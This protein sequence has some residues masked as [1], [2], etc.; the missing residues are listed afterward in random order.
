MKRL[1]ANIL[2]LIIFCT[3]GLWALDDKKYNT[4]LD[5]D[6]SVAVFDQTKGSIGSKENGVEFSDDANIHGGILCKG[7]TFLE[8]A[9]GGTSG[10]EI[11]GKR[12]KSSFNMKVKGPG[13][14]YFNVC[15]AIDGSN[16]DALLVYEDDPEETEEDDIDFADEYSEN[17]WNTYKENG[18]M[19]GACGLMFCPD[20]DLC[21]HDDQVAGHFCNDNDCDATPFF[22]AASFESFLTSCYTRTITFAVTEAFRDEDYEDPDPDGEYV[23]LEKVYLDNFIWVPDEDTEIFYFSEDDGTEFGE[24]GL[25]VE[26]YTDYDDGVFTFYYT[27][28]GTVP[29]NKSTKYITETVESEEEEISPGVFLSDTTTLRVAVY[30]GDTLVSDTYTAT[31]TRRKV[32]QPPQCTVVNDSPFTT[33]AI[34]RFSSEEDVDNYYYTLDGSDP[35]DY[36]LRG[37]SCTITAPC[38]VKVIA[39]YEG[40]VSA[41][42]TLDLKQMPSPLP[43]WKA[44]GYPAAD[45]VVFNESATLTLAS[46]AGA[47]IYYR[48]NGGESQE[49]TVPI[50]LTS[51]CTLEYQALGDTATLH[52]P[53]TTISIAKAATTW[54]GITDG[55]QAKKW[56]LWGCTKEIAPATSVAIADYLQPYGYDPATK[57]MVRV[58]MVEPG[59]AYWVYGKPAGTAPTFKTTGVAATPATGTTWHLVSTGATWG[60]NGY[61]FY[62]VTEGTTEAIPG[63]KEK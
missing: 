26:F 40:V 5:I 43:T 14:L 36:G 45:K 13:T 15:A 57:S 9:A 7:E 12:F 33:G 25:T 49:Y 42:T 41:V 23:I 2:L 28:D 20:G 52:S 53:I 56:N 29:T 3:T 46:A 6:S 10:Y 51:A 48:V 31:Y 61:S 27:T 63:W 58:T 21:E 30:E 4:V 47:K 11:R 62:K 50:T 8:M 39:E 1:A 60:W 19:Y 18:E 37:Y 24:D 54:S 34:V 17:T 16:D 22:E 38:V 35:T 44:D 59:Q 32:V 55:L